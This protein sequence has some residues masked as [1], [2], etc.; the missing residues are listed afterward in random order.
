LIDARAALNAVFL[1]FNIYFSWPDTSQELG[2]NTRLFFLPP[3]LESLFAAFRPL[4]FVAV[5]CNRS[6]A[7][8]AAAAEFL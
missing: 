3:F 4:G 6:R 2:I 5:V 1:T 7:A 8:A